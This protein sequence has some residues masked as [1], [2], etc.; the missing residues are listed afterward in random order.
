M[1]RLAA[2]VAALCVVLAACSDPE[3]QLERARTQ[4]QQAIAAGDRKTA[5]D[6]IAWLQRATPDD[7]EAIREQASLLIQAG[8]AP[9]V[10][11]LL[12]D[13]VARFPDDAM[14]RLL[15]AEA[16]LLVNDPV[17]ATRAAEA[18]PAD[19]EA[20]WAALLVRARATMALGDLDA[21]L[22]LFERAEQSS[23]DR[24]E[25]RTPRIAALLGER[26]FED[27]ARAVDAARQ[28]LADVNPALVASLELALHQYRASDARQRVQLAE[29]ERDAAAVARARED[30]DGVLADL[31]ALARAAPGN[32]GAWQIWVQGLLATARAGE[33]AAA[34]EQARAESPET[35][36]LLPLLAR[37]RL[38][39]A[40]PEAA[41]NVLRE[42]AGHD[43]ATT[44]L[45]L[46]RFLA[47][48]ARSA[49]A[50]TVL[51]AARERAPD[52]PQLA[53][54]RAELLL[55]GGQ[56]DAAEAAIRELP[57]LPPRALLEAR[58]RLARGDARGAVQ[59]LERLAPELDIAPTHFWLARA[60]EAAG[61]RTGAE[62]RYA[63]A[64]LRAPAEPGA[65]AELVR[66]ARERGAWRDVAAAGQQ[67]VLR[68]PGAI[69]GWQALVAAFLHLGETAA[70]EEVA[71]RAV[72]LL[73]DDPDPPLLVA[74]SLRA[75]G[76]NLE[77]LEA[78][79]AARERFGSRSELA[80][81]RALALAAD[82]RH[83][84]ALAETAR[85][86]EREPDAASLH[87][88]R[89]VV[90][91]GAGRADEGTQAVDAALALD[92]DDPRPLRTRCRFLAA[93]GRFDAA[94][95][96]C[97]R[98]LAERPDDAEILFVL[99]SA[100]DAGG[101]PDAAIDAYRRAAE[102]DLRAA[103][104]RNNLAA[105]LSERG[106]LD[107]ALAAAQQAYALADGNPHVLDTLGELY[108]AKGLTDR[109]IALLEKAHTLDPTLSIAELHLALAYAEAGRKPD[110]QRHLNA[111]LARRE[112]APQHERARR[113]LANL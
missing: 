17:R 87:Y 26:R 54:A 93:S 104:P 51:D 95:L 108:L 22:V 5:L 92:P 50:M 56:L 29:Q 82:G 88:V 101:D 6:A 109:A 30:L 36:A 73:P 59:R 3:E 10:V 97:R 13:A 62:R 9:R 45:P 47:A 28:D 103:A 38:A 94:L 20:A 18:I 52:D 83:E 60:L 58:S 42:L 110:A 35:L 14:L 27:A 70:A 21:A 98:Y 19:A 40:E 23:P 25:L 77:A 15:L 55:D 12:E 24:P 7:P 41:E 84:Q 31:G 68:A 71:R 44:S 99:G 2:L 113:A 111:L 39:L 80:A 33:A 32:L 4:A 107:A 1:D 49:E 69:D 100:L 61:D 46:A 48:R 34:L 53:Q 57:D 16:A 63:L 43:P 90:L 37:V 67:L 86:L 74:R 78:L 75:Q 112:A 91:F 81:E 89:A 64:A 11:W 8:E 76:R 72:A 106:E 65:Y 96:D 85:A 79:A 102:L 66:L 105:L